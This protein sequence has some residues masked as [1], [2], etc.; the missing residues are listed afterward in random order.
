MSHMFEINKEFYT[1]LQNYASQHIILSQCK[2]YQ[3]FWGYLDF[4]VQQFLEIYGR[5]QFWNLEGS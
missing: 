3:W 1:I 4:L 2:T 5:S